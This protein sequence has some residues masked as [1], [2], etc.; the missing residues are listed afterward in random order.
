[1]K[2]WSNAVE[3]LAGTRLRG[4]AA[5]Y[6]VL[7]IALLI[8]GAAWL[9]Y[10]TGGIRYVFSHSV[11]VPVVLAAF[12]FGAPGGLIAG[13]GAGLALG[14]YMPVDTHTGEMQSTLNWSYRLF[15]LSL[16]GV[17]TGTLVSLLRGHIRRVQWLSHHDPETGILNSRALFA[18]VE[19]IIARGRRADGFQIFVIDLRNY[20]D[21]TS[22]LGPDVGSQ[23]CSEVAGRLRSFLAPSTAVCVVHTQRLA[24]A[25]PP[26]CPEI[27]VP[28]L[29]AALEEPYL[30]RDIPIHIDV[31]IGSAQFPSHADAPDRLLQKAIIAV[32]SAGQRGTTYLGYSIEAD[33]TSLDSLELLGELSGA[34]KDGQLR[35]FY[36]PK[37][38]LR[39]S[40][41]EGVEAL[42][43]WQH[44]RRGM[45][46]PGMFIPSVENSA[47]VHSMTIWV[48]EQAVAQLVAWRDSGIGLRIAINVSMRNLQEKRLVET[49]ESLLADRSVPSHM[50]EIEV[51]ESAL[52]MDAREAAR[53]F[54]RW[55]GLGAT[56]AI[57][58]FGTGHASLAYVRDL[59]VDV[60]KIDQTFIRSIATNERDRAI[61][62]AAV[63]LAQDLRLR[64]VAEG[65]EDAGTM[66]YLRDLGCDY[67]QG[68]GI[69]RPL[70]PDELTAWF[71]GGSHDYRLHRRQPRDR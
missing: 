35:L 54:E 70:P 71:T 9:V 10:A 8:G 63:D 4:S 41:I 16:V 65:V 51:T 38:E 42:V 37:V 11:Y 67:A 61:V 22:T 24:F 46:G 23:L 26:G 62:H 2:P 1:M 55:R 31:A 18:E 21:I 20:Q 28:A 47:L 52:L 6:A 59:P 45:V 69:Q 44:P 53:L 58:D 66:D 5:A 32:H 50:L 48:F 40:G 27:D 43:R 68:F 64:T 13:I 3:Q 56:I 34:M 39:G 19:R 49:I 29:R 33:R 25:V 12:L 15:F 30:V 36:Q 17:V 14:P 57:D 7:A 60:L